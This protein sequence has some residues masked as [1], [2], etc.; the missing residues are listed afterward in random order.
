MRKSSRLP[1]EV[2]APYLLEIPAPRMVRSPQAAGDDPAPP[3]HETATAS[4]TGKQPLDWPEVFGNDRPVEIEIGFGKG[5]FLLNASAARSNRNFLGIEKERAYTL[6]TATRIAKRQRGNVRLISADARWLLKEW[7][8]E[9]SVHALH[10][11]FPD[12]WWKKRHHKRRLFN[13]EFA[14]R[15]VQVLQPCGVLHFA[16]DVKEYFEMSVGML[17]G[18]AGLCEMPAEADAELQTNFERKAL[19]RDQEVYRARFERSR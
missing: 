4:Y 17:R 11:Y 18:L 9:A 19:E 13:E 6:F 14:A 1:L 5:L 12:P 3:P 8:A 10:I 15:L 2:L 16:T 7:I